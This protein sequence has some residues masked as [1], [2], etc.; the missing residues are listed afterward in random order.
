MLDRRLDPDGIMESTMRPLSHG[1][2]SF[3]RDPLT[4]LET[5]NLA[6]SQ[7]Q[8]PSP[9]QR[10]HSGTGR[11][12]SD[13][14]LMAVPR[15]GTTR[16]RQ[17]LVGPWSWSRAP[18]DNPEHKRLLRNN[19]C[20]SICRACDGLAKLRKRGHVSGSN[21]TRFNSVTLVSRTE[22]VY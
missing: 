4:Y 6:F 15:Y 2:E 20:L 12:V 5:I 22:S 11:P 1:V 19:L 16:G 13:S 17:A 10:S 3:Q 21:I 8:F 7:S 9:L 18:S 14:P